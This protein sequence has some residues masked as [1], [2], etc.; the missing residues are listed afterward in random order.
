MSYK[1]YKDLVMRDLRKGGGGG[2]GYSGGGGGGYSGGYGGYNAGYGNRGTGS[3]GMPVD[4]V[5]ALVVIIVLVIVC[6][7]CYLKK[8]N[9]VLTEDDFRNTNYVKDIK[10]S[11]EKQMLTNTSRGVNSPTDGSYY[12]SYKAADSATTKHGTANLEFVGNGRGYDIRGILR[13]EDGSSEIQEG[14]ATYDGKAY[15]LDKNQGPA[16]KSLL[17]FSNGTFNF[18]TNTFT[19]QWKCNMAEAHGEYLSFYLMKSA[20]E[21]DP[22]T[23]PVD[24]EN[25]PATPIVPVP[26]AAPANPVSSDD[27]F[28]DN[29]PS[30]TS[31]TGNN[32]AEPSIF[33]QLT[34][35]R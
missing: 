26:P 23:A 17:V 2:G 1:D 12:F 33:D 13:D 31:N 22:E 14:V 6:Y 18:E 9:A 35:K 5:I 11:M 25:A 30:S 28:D 24:E 27:K 16:S 7:C 29:G 15:W 3:G 34:G 21:E 32:N 19:G 10:E 20:N 8:K 4:L